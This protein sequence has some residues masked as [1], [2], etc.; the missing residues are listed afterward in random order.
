M[1]NEESPNNDEIESKQENE[2]QLWLRNTV[3]R[4][5]YCKLFHENGFETMDEVLTIT[6]T[7]LKEL[8][9]TKM[10][11]RRQILNAIKKLSLGTFIAKIPSISILY[12]FIVYF[13]FFVCFVF[14][15]T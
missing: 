7:D 2:V 12:D 15:Q 9:I 3:S 11:H 5:E 8:G 13:V 6:E 4:E 1:A 14:S 10:G